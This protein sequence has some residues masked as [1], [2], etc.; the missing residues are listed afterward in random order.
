VEAEMRIPNAKGGVWDPARIAKLVQ[1]IQDVVNAAEMVD[2]ADAAVASNKI[3]NHFIFERP[4][5]KVGVTK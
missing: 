3:K 1:L 5:D 4:R 2:E